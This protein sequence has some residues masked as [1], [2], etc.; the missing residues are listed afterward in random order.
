LL[1]AHC[2][3]GLYGFNQLAIITRRKQNV[4]LYRAEARAV[5]VLVTELDAGKGGKAVAHPA[6]H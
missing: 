3:T 6:F 2:V 5:G 1:I 4:F